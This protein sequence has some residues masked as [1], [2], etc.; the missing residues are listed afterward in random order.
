MCG[1]SNYTELK[2]KHWRLMT[3]TYIFNYLIPLSVSFH[4]QEFVTDYLYDE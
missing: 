4:I 3:L 2:E 1:D